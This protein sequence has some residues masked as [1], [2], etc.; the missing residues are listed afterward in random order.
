MKEWFKKRPKC[1][2]VLIISSYLLVYGV[3][4]FRLT[5]GSGNY[6][7][8]NLPYFRDHLLNLAQNFSW[9]DGNTGA[10]LGYASS[11]YLSRLLSMTYYLHLPAEIVSYLVII[12]P[13]AFSSYFMYII[14]RRFSNGYLAWM[15]GLGV[16]LNPAFFYKILAGHVV[17]FFSFS[18]FLYL[19]YYLLAKFNKSLRSTMILG[20]LLAFCGAQIQ[21]FIFA[22]IVCIFYF[23]THRDKFSL[24]YLLLTI[25]IVFIVNLPWLLNFFNGSISAVVS[26][27]IAKADAFRELSHGNLLYISGLLFTKA[28]LIHYFYG[29]AFLAFFMGLTGIGLYSAVVAKKNQDYYFLL[30]ILLAFTI[31]ATGI[32]NGINIPPFTYLSSVLREVGH[33]A[34]VFVA[35]LMLLINFAWDRHGK[36]IQRIIYLYLIIFLLL[37][38]KVFLGYI[39]LPYPDFSNIRSQFAKFETQNVTDQS[40]YRILTYPFFGQYSF[41]NVEK[42]YVDSDNNS[43]LI[44]NSGWDNFT[45]NAGKENFNNSSTPSTLPHSIQFDFAKSRDLSKLERLGIKYIYDYSGIYQSNIEKYVPAGVYDNNLGLIKNPDLIKDV[46]KEYPS[47]LEEVASDIY[48]L[49]EAL[50][51]ISL[52]KSSGA[53]LKF[54][55]IDPTLYKVTISNLKQKTNL[56]FLDAYNQKW[57]ILP[58]DSKI[59]NC[60]IIDEQKTLGVS[61]CQKETVSAASLKI[62]SLRETSLYSASHTKTIDDFNQWEID[63]SSA[64]NGELSFFIFFQPEGYFRIIILGEYI[65]IPSLFVI[66]MLLK[67]KKKTSN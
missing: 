5:K 37:N 47:R 36:I 34:P 22:A 3:L 44:N 54:E 43:S 39:N 26:A 52:E 9:V 6:W 57:E 41:N 49:N 40:T 45:N 51:R 4:F 53:S 64:Q 33:F 65:L 15:L 16:I 67:L 61:E 30:L 21:F 66:V 58:S 63:P 38:I 31:G 10:P 50:P 12:V 18:I 29:K 11:L 62:S 7:D 56:L 17:Y 20:L 32:V 55:K 1:L 27:G 2:S 35:F 8:W 48:R 60:K 23:L 14:S 28:T 13:A 46:A 42:R 24:K 59:G 19:V 25:S